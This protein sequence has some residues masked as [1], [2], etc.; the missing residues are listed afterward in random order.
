MNQEEPEILNRQ[1]T[2]SEIEAV[3]KKLPTNK[4]PSPD[5]F[6]GEFYLTFPEEL[7]PLLLKRFCKIQEEGRLSNSF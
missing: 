7:T 6:T 2:P 1:I 4:N 3:I 5:G